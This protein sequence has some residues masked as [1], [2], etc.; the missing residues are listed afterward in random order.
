[1]E[2]PPQMYKTAETPLEAKIGAI[3]EAPFLCY[4]SFLGNALPITAPTFPAA[5]ERP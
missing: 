3:I 2:I 1:M 4:T 5:A